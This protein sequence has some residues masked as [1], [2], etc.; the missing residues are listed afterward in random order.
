MLLYTYSVAEAIGTT[1]SRVVISPTL[2]SPPD[3]DDAYGIDIEFQPAYVSPDWDFVAI[4]A[5]GTASGG[6]VST[7]GDLTDVTLT[8]SPTLANG[9]VLTYDGSV[10]KQETPAAGVTDHTL[11]SNIG[12]NTHAQ[13]D[14][15][16]ATGSPI[17]FLQSEISITES[18]ISDLQSYLLDITGQ[19]INDLSDV[20]VVGS[21]T[22]VAGMV[23]AYNG[24]KWNH[25]TS[26]ALLGFPL[27][28]PDGT[29]SAPSYSFSGSTNTG[30]YASGSNLRFATG[31][32]D[33]LIIESGGDVGIGLTNPTTKLQL[34]NTGS[35]GT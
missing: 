31:G 9:M 10:W 22:L 34:H 28:A 27:L 16:I 11:L 29:V 8:G 19:S 13:I 17:H 30:M 26:D 5:T 21:P 20:D 6:G 14:T 4:S 3:T 2:G 12:T 35:N 7:L 32:N 15:H 23:L 24:T 18:Q 25:Q 1:K 33:S